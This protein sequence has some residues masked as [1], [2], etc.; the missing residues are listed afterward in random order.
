MKDHDGEKK[1]ESK[2]MTEEE[3]E[4]QAAMMKIQYAMDPHVDQ[5]Q[6]VSMAE[7]LEDDSILY[8]D[9][10]NAKKCLLV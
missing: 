6:T 4:I 7:K 9:E 10:V 8:M 3:E 2:R 5:D 1:E